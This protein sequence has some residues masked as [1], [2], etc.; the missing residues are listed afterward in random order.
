[1]MPLVPPEDI[2]YMTKRL[3]TKA[4]EDMLGVEVKV[5][6]K[7]FVTPVT[8]MG[9]DAAIVQAA[10][11]SYANGT[12]TVR[13][14]RALISYLFEMQHGSPFE[15][16]EMVW[17]MKLPIFIAR[18]L[19]RHRTAS[20]NEISGRYSVLDAD[21]FLPAINDLRTQSNKN[22]QMSEGF[23]GEDEASE[24]HALME[25]EQQTLKGN[26][27]T[28]VQNGVARELARIDLPLATYTTWFWKMDLRNFLH[29]AGLRMDPHAQPECQA[30][31]REMYRFAQVVAPMA[32]EAFE[33]FQLN[34][35][36]FSATELR[37]LQ[38]GLANGEDGFYGGGIYEEMQSELGSRKMRAFFGK[39]GLPMIG[40]V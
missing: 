25:F 24:M 15:M 18:Q 12:K 8:Y 23:L 22:K 40:E 7:G 29:L 37:F 38:R 16:V 39:L 2:R 3:T 33:E 21:M 30:Y 32:C 36:R 35:K 11:V 19:V 1:M 17:M 6:D 31:A 5:L 9:G 26:Y 27:D 28:Y 10:R 20:L 13:E 14:D 4:A 34:A